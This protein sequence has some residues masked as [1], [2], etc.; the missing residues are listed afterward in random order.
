MFDRATFFENVKLAPFGNRLTQQQVDGCDRVLTCWETLN[1]QGLD[2]RALAYVFATVFHETGG[3]MEPVREGFAKTDAQARKILADKKYAKVD[4]V[5]GYAYYGRGYVQLTWKENYERV[6]KALGIDLVNDPDL[7]MD[8]ETS[9]MILVRGMIEGLY[10]PGQ[11]L[12]KYFGLGKRGPNNDP[13]GARAIVN[14]KDKANLIAGYQDQFL[15]AI[16]KSQLKAHADA[17]QTADPALPDPV[18]K[19]VPVDKPV[20]VKDKATIGASLQAV[21]GL[22]A[23]GTL[24]GGL[25]QN[26]NNPWAFAAFGLVFVTVVAGAY[27]YVTGRLSIARKGGV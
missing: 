23:V 7:A 24:G 2:G 26:L 5:T 17:K 16:N 22:A 18:K 21:G 1:P 20:L 4:P 15:G 11:N 25:M 8:E 6:G 19:E 14:G 27:L 13:V 9:V 10:T 12:S 3:R